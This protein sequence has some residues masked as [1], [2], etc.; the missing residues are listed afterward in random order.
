MISFPSLYEENMKKLLGD[1]QYEA[2]LH[3]F[4]RN[5]WQGLRVNTAKISVEEYKE[6]CSQELRPVPWCPTGFYLTGETKDFSKHPDYAAGLYYLQEPS[7]MAPA[8]ILPIE[9]GDWVL[10]LCAAPGGKSTALSAK[11]G[12]SGVLVSN[13][14]SPSRA[15]ALLKN[16][17]LQ[18]ATQAIVLSEP[19]YKLSQRFAGKFQKILVDAPCSGE[20]MFHKEP[21]IMKNWEQYGNEYYVKLQREILWEAVKM[22]APGGMLLYST[23][24]FAPVED[25]KMIE[26]VL[27]K[28]PDLSLLPIIKVGGMEDGH[29]EWSE[30]GREDLTMTARFWPH[31]LE[32]QGHFAA[33]LQKKGPSAGPS[34]L[35][36]VDGRGSFSAKD[37]ELWQSWC[38]ESFF[39]HWREVLPANGFIQKLGEKLYYSPVE[40]GALAGLRVLRN[41]I[42]LGELKKDR[43][44]PGQA[45]AMTLKKGDCQREAELPEEE[46]VRYL[47]G[48]T[49]R[50][51]YEDGWTLVMFGGY[52]LGWAKAVK[53][54]LKNKYL[55][56]WMLS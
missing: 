21:T 2:Y 54:Q 32:G 40:Q 31:K 7:A 52:P 27:S 13:D 53:G 30:S 9:A 4:E 50:G 5:Y 36:D 45:F 11:L 42:L 3:T 19:P 48:E 51:D 43:F 55:K 6:R 56:G 18:G 41:G 29:P 15:K 34:S 37:M 17:E 1:E 14:I 22:L 23:C 8:A 38:D 44:E 49:L 24:T 25:E 16:L 12:R 46:A 47:K 33:L 20:G 39:R 10:D 28:H 35:N 26:E